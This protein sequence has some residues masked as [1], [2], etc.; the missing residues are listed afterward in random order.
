MS[1][2]PDEIATYL[3]ILEETPKRIAAASEGHSADA[4]QAKPDSESWS[5]NEI[6][7]H[8]RA[9][10]D[11]WGKDIRRM[12]TE[13][14]PTWR[15]LSPRTWMRKTDYA[16][17]P[18]HESFAIFVKERQ[19]LLALLAELPQA[20]WSRSANVIQRGKDREQTV[21]LRARQMAMH[22]EGHCEQIEALLKP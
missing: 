16:D 19:E 5:A 12:L 3:K 14:H 8:L 21:F 20:D 9:C 15:H 17:Q 4:L 22:E 7:A 18:F 13:D 10:V 6:V 2:P 1:V 11:V